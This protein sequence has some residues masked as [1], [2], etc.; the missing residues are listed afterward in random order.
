MIAVPL[1][2]AV[3]LLESRDV[4]NGLLSQP[5]A[6]SLL[7]ILLGFDPVSV[8][9]SAAAVHLYYIGRHPSGASLYPEFPFGFFLVVS[10]GPANTYSLS[11]YLFA[12]LMIAAVSSFTAFVLKT[13]RAVF[14]KYRDRLMFYKKFPS[15]LSAVVFTYA[16]YAA[17]SLVLHIILKNLFII[18]SEVQL[19]LPSELEGSR[20]PVLLCLILAL[21]YFFTR[22]LRLTN[23]R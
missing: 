1:I 20:I 5:F 19:P 16:V 18:V 7:L 21:R 13:K 9:V 8:T 10:S 6:V 3:I 22:C 23:D 11:T 14:E 4:F 17:Y 15:I 12:F 2:S